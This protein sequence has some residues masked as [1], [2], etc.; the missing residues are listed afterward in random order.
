MEVLKPPFLE[1][2]ISV[3]WEGKVSRSGC[4][5]PE[6]GLPAVRQTMTQHLGECFRGVPLTV[7]QQLFHFRKAEVKRGEFFF[8]SG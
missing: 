2:D 4:A 8:K 5:Y 1:R 3:K 7:G 6:S